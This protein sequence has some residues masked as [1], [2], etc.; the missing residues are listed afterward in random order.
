MIIDGRIVHF[1]ESFTT[2]LALIQEY[3]AQY[4]PPKARQLTTNID[5]YALDVIA[6][7]PHMFAEY[8]G[9]LTPEKNL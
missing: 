6:L 3:A 1:K 4:S 2:Q 7:N 5:N 8:S 9:K